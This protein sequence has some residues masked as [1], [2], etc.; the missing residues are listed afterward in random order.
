VNR[1]GRC[2]GVTVK[3]QEAPVTF[4]NTPAQ[5]HLASWSDPT[6]AICGERL[7]G[8]LAPADAP[9]CETCTVLAEAPWTGVTRKPTNPED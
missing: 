2:G 8:V 1:C 4:D 7:I 9:H 5:A 6:V 3:A